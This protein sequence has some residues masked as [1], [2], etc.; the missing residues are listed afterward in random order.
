V[1]WGDGHGQHVLQSDGSDTPVPLVAIGTGASWLR[2]GSAETQ[3]PFRLGVWSSTGPRAAIHRST[4]RAIA[5]EVVRELVQDDLRVVR[6][7]NDGLRIPQ[8]T[9][10]EFATVVRPAEAQ[11]AQELYFGLRP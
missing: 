2:L 4:P 9:P 7:G 10:E 1:R 6:F 11:P 5:P 8:I 3:G